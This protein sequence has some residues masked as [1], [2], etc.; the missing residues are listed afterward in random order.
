MYTLDDV[1]TWEAAVAV[2]FETGQSNLAKLR[3][4][5]RDNVHE[6]NRNEADTRLHL[7]DRIIFDC[8]GWEREDC[9]SEELYEGKYT[10]YSLG[11]PAR[12]LVV[13]AKKEG[14]YFD[15]PSGFDKR[16]CHLRT[17]VDADEKVNL[18]IRQVLGYCQTRG[19]SVGAMCNGHQLVAFLASRD[20]GVPPVEGL[21]LVF[22]SL[23]EML[24]DFRTLWQDLS[25][26]G[27]AAHNIHATLKS[28]MLAPPPEKLSKRLYD[29]PGFK[30]RNSFQTELKILGELF[31]ED[32]AQTPQRE[33]DFL[34]ECYCPSGALSQYASISKQIL[35][36][37]YSTLLQKEIEAPNLTPAQQKA[38]IARD[39]IVDM[40][41]AGLKRRP[42]IILGDV[43]VGKTTFV[44]HFIRVDATDILERAIVLY[45]DFGKEPALA[46]DLQAFV[47]RR[48]EAQLR[49]TYGIDVDRAEFVRGVYHG[50][51]IRFS[52]GI[53]AEL[54]KVDEGAYAVKELEFLEA[55]LRDRSAHLRACLEHISSG[56]K[57]Q[58]VIFLDNVDQRPFEFQDQVFLIGHSLAETWPAT[59]F[60][61]LRPGTFFH[62]RAKGSLS[63]YQPR[64]FT[65]APPRIDLVIK[66]RMRFAKQQLKDTGRLGSFPEALALTSATLETYVGVILDSFERN[67]RLVSFIDNLSG[68]NVRTALDFI[69]AFVGSGHVDAYKILSITKDTGSYTIPVH[70]FLRAVMFGDHEHYDPAASPVANLFDITQPDG[71]EHFLLAILLSYIERVGSIGG[72]EGYVEIQKVYDFAQ[73]LGFSPPQVRSALRRAEEKRLLDS[74][75]RFS[76]SQAQGQF[77]I[78]TIGSY[79]AHDLPRDFTYVDAVIVDTPI[80]DEKARQ[81]IADSRAVKAR[82]DRCKAFR[83]Y[84]DAQW[85]PLADKDSGYEWASISAGL[86][87]NI[88]FILTKL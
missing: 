55:R 35:Q 59:V 41:S 85:E 8:L 25:K 74:S 20:D 65:V 49:E 70:E 86:A 4:W 54:R 17:V 76:D 63:A 7:I 13:E 44:R 53:Y 62:S 87:A 2:D 40:M 61:S 69:N 77:R 58:V 34:R 81:G 6:G 71:R 68:G 5:E 31:I 82:L 23:G 19:V 78:T 18:A 26:P 36:S 11:R 3:A 48:C 60:I 16:V 22:P 43:G 72:S 56:Q 27:L 1:R 37:R 79:T 15:L 10:D 47:L 80:V 21:A 14:L 12:L 24:T 28:H 45:V 83:A 32:I 84:L 57:Q 38:G 42:I 52:K 9:F 30:N 29:Y 33:E 46:E 39:L 51:L 75:P 50:Q 67:D 64:V 88:E 66:K 73:G